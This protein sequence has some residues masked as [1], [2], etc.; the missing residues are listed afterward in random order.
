M[1]FHNNWLLL[2]LIAPLLWALVVL[3]DD[4][5]LRKVYRSAGFGAM[6]AGL[7]GIFPFLYLSITNDTYT[8]PPRVMAAAITAGILT[9]GFY[10][11][12]FKALATEEPSTAVAMLNL[13]PVLVVVLAAIFLKETLVFKQYLGLGAIILSSTYLG[14]L[15]A[16]RLKFSKATGYIFMGV[17]LIAVASILSKYSYDQATFRTVFAWVSFGLFVAG[18]SIFIFAKHGPEARRIARKS[19]LSLVLVL[20]TIEILNFGAEFTQ[21]LAISRGP[22]SAVRAIEGVQPLYML[23]LAIILG[24]VMPA[25]FREQIDKKFPKKVITMLLMIGGLYLIAS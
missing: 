5:L 10:Y 13:M 9:V 17:I 3:I 19:G 15:E 1:L 6:V 24:P 11:F 7:F 16:R 21:G 18:A 8:L 4:N 22:V 2:A 20:I 12:Y 23:L 14:L 25:F